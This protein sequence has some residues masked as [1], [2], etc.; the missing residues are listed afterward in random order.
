MYIITAKQRLGKHI[1]EGANAQN[2]M[3]SIAR[4]RISKHV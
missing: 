1:P 2:N 3:A 4:Q